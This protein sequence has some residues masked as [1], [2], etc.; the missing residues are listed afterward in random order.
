M[1][2][3][4]LL[5]QPCLWRSIFQSA[6]H[7]GQIDAIRRLV[8]WYENGKYVE[9]SRAD[10][11]EFLQIG[12]REG[13]A[14][15]QYQLGRYYIRGL[16]NMPCS[17]LEAVKYYKL[18]ASQGHELACRVLKFDRCLLYPDSQE[19]NIN[20][21]L[22]DRQLTTLQAILNR[23][24]DKP[25]FLYGYEF[26]WEEAQVISN[27][28]IEHPYFTVFCLQDSL[29]RLLLAFELRGFQ[30]DHDLKFHVV[31]GS[32]SEPNLYGCAFIAFDKESLQDSA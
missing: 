13:D 24:C 15:C 25:C 22:Q 2:F 1:L 12:A 28:M 29:N 19:I 16:G 31:T 23:H 8:D 27:A 7:Q 10:A 18:A 3:Y 11:A 17:F 20:N 26:D 14:E 5:I 32:N 9:E 21:Y 6:A 30:P 4:L